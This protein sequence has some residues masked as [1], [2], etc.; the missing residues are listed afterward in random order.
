M[1]LAGA[2]ACGDARVPAAPIATDA[3]DARADTAPA[4][5]FDS[6][7][8][9]KLRA[10]ATAYVTDGH[11]PGVAFSVT[12]KDGAVCDGA[13][14]QADLGVRLAMPPDGRF[15]VGSITKTFVAAVI[16]QLVDEKALA[17][18]DPVARWLPTFPAGAV[19]LE[20]LLDHT[21]GLADYLFDP[22]LQATQ[23]QAHTRA[24]LLAIA[25]QVQSGAATPGTWRYS[26]TNYLLLGA[27]IEAATGAPWTTQVR[28]RILD[29][30]ELGLTST[31]VYGF[32]PVPG[33]GVHGYQDD[34]AGWTDRTDLTH[35]TV[36]DAAGCMVSSMPDLGRFWRALNGG[37]LFS[38]ASLDAMR[39]HQ[40]PVSPGQFWG[41]GVESQDGGAVGTL[42]G[43]GGGFGGYASQMQYF[44][45]PN[46]TLTVAVNASIPN[47][48][49]LELPDPSTHVHKGIRPQLWQAILGL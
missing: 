40:V 21:S 2:I 41:L 43:H 28:R 3:G 34:G 49:P 32:E 38:R 15:R 39:K 16:L 18:S 29:R 30:P 25:A 20:R 8:C 17:L 6:A 47:G 31:F 5:P 44:D 36:M 13:A 11:T 19:T 37:A 10:L 24:E 23:A 46:V 9:E 48:D 33:A 27:I 45:G 22:S 12:A 4:P 7:L 1:V 26:N 14:G 35:P 42:Y